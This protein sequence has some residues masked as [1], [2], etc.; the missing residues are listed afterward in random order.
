MKVNFVTF[1]TDTK[2]GQQNYYTESVKRL[3]ESAK[4]WGVENFDLYTPDN[5]PVSTAVKKWMTDTYDPGYGFYS[6]KPL[7]ILE[8]FKHMDYGDVA[9]Y[10]D[11]GRPEY[12][13]EFRKDFNPLINKVI[14]QYN[15]IGVAQGPFINKQWCKEDCFQVMECTDEKYYNANHL[16]ATWH[17]WEK[18]NLTI[19]VL[20][21]WLLYCFH[22][23]GIVTTDDK[24]KILST[25]PGFTQ[26]RWDQAILTNLLL[27]YKYEKNLFT[28]LIETP[29]KWEKD[30]N[31]F[32]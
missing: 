19:E 30:I 27:K 11:A 32:C 4:K 12:N 3:V 23:S 26:H 1:F 2:F 16:C 24:T 13:Y 28:P 22:P 8:S 18:S 15:G 31:N 5:L 6:W 14:S 25:Y 20:E 7:V 10:Y 9:L 21:K 29:D 17:I